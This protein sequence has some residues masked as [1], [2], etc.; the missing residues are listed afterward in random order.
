MENTE[1]TTNGTK[2]VN[3]TINLF[4]P[5]DVVPILENNEHV[6]R[7]LYELA[8]IFDANEFHMGNRLR[9]LDGEWHSFNTYNQN[10]PIVIDGAYFGEFEAAIIN[11]HLGGDVRGNYSSPYIVE[12]YDNVLSL[13]TQDTELY[14]ELSDGR[15]FRWMCENGEAYFDLD[16]LDVYWI[17]F[18]KPLTEK[19]LKS[20]EDNMGEL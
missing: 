14:I 18:G 20:I 4:T 12:G 2:I 1:Q 9:K 11:F 15:E 17:D 10:A 19:Q 5:N 7:A 3:C 6:D 16:D 8:D 13:I